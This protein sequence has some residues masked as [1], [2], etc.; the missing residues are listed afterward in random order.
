M[1]LNCPL[2]S[3]LL[4][5]SAHNYDSAPAPKIRRIPQNTI[6]PTRYKYHNKTF[7]LFKRCIALNIRLC[8]ISQ[9]L[10]KSYTLSTTNV[11]VNKMGQAFQ[12]EFG[13]Y[14]LDQ[15]YIGFG[16]WLD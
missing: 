2:C 16:H 4:R 5:I 6:K 15:T 13:H 11:Y 7:L 9:K 8:N 12:I 14:A 3:I 10:R 1:G